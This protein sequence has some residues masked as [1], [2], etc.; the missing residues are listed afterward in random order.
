M[1]L[2]SRDDVVAILGNAA[3]ARQLL[4]KAGTATYDEAAIDNCIEM[5]DADV[6]AAYGQRYAAISSSPPAKIR[7]LSARLAAVYCWQRG[8][9]NLAMPDSVEQMLKDVGLELQRI[10]DSE[11]SPGG[12]PVSRYPARIDN[13]RGGR[14]AVVSTWRRAGLLGGR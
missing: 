6:A 8:A 11:T 4:P 9:R 14:R 10:G 13:T 3:T 5:A 7:F 12:S 1:P 2:C